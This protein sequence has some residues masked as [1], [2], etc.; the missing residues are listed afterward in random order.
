MA[1]VHDIGPLQPKNIQGRS[2]SLIS[3]LVFV[4]LQQLYYRLLFE[5]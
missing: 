4:V 1:I 5:H 3:R 2:V